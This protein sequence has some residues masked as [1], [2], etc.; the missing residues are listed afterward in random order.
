[1]IGHVYIY[2]LAFS[3][4]LIF[5]LRLMHLVCILLNII[6]NTFL[7]RN[8]IPTTSHFH[9]MFIPAYYANIRGGNQCWFTVYYMHT[10]WIN[11]S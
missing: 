5:A 2:N 6:L 1:M 3:F 9:H 11:G 8:N 7:K 10:V 4:I